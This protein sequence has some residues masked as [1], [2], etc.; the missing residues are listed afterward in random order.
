MN[1]KGFDAACQPG[2]WPGF[3]F[4]RALF[5]RPAIMI[6]NQSML[7]SPSKNHR[8][9]K[10]IRAIIISNGDEIARNGKQWH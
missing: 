7:A 8:R 2:N 10:I 5:D 1:E 6:G 3:S 9:I 4:Q